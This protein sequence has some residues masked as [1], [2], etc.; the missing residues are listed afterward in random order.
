[1]RPFTKEWI[2]AALD[3]LLTIE[4]IINNHHLTHIVAF[5]SQQCIEKLMKALMEEKEIDT[6]KIHKL[7]KLQKFI[8]SDLDELDEKVLNTLDQLYIE[9]RY[10]GELGLLPNGKPTLKD[11]QEFYDFAQKLFD[12]V[13]KKFNVD[14]NEILK[15]Q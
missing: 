15:S 12:D 8:H 7:T 2:K 9:S 6:P 10:P 1:M 13:C 14:K 3:D 5:H 4:E 11:A